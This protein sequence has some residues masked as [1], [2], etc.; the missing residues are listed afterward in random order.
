MKKSYLLLGMIVVGSV[1]GL[2]AMQNLTQEQIE[3][4]KNVQGGKVYKQYLLA[5]PPVY[6]ILDELT[7]PEGTGKLEVESKI[8]WPSVFRIIDSMQGVIDVNE[9][10]TRQMGLTLLE[11]A[12][13]AGNLLAAKTLLEKYKANPNLTARKPHMRGMPIPPNALM[14]ASSKGDLA[15]V[16][17]LLKHGADPSITDINGSNSLDYVQAPTAAYWYNPAVL[18]ILKDALMNKRSAARAA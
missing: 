18:K 3:E 1:A 2:N 10:R 14:M 4:I 16:G 13:D 15:M 12:A 5:R 9:Y 6:K 11:R 7:S 17:L 8:D